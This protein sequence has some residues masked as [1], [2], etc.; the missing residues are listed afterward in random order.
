LEDPLAKTALD[1]KF[2]SLLAGRRIAS[3]STENHDAS[4]HLTAV[5]YLYQEG[6][7]YVATSSRTRKARNLSARPRATI[8]VE[9]RKA[10]SESGVTATG[11]VEILSGE[12]AR[13][14]NARIHGRYLSAEALADPQVGP[15]FAAFD[16]ICIRV[17]PVSWTWWDMAELDA[18]VL[19]R[20]FAS[21]PSYLLAQE[22]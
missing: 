22:F 16:D 10:G 15:V 7:F 17:L 2:L 21:N 14:W 13:G 11:P 12:K 6:S 1:P 18:M 20:R 9:A 8:M 4:P 5:G 19:G 3:F